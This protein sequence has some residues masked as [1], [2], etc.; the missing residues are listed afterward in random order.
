VSLEFLSPEPAGG[1]RFT[2][3]ARSPMERVA[4]EAGARFE[5]RDGWSVA[6]DYDVPGPNGSADSA[7]WADVS[8]LGKLELQAAPA[9]LA[10]LADVELRLGHAS[11]A[12]D[13]WWLPLHPERV[14]VVGEPAPVRALRGRLEERAT[15]LDVTTV[16]AAM[17]ILGP[18]ARDVI[19]RFCALDLRDRVT[20]VGGLRPGSIARTPGTIVREDADRFLMLFGAALGEHMWTVVADAA[21]HLGGRPVG[22]DGLP[23]L[24]GVLAGA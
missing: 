19:A 1:D 17:T 5:V 15:V 2:P 24:E 4:R 22:V 20:P 8:H 6:V 21:T 10:A 13:A 11:R 16:F 3:I 14:L 12:G 18:R 7:A 23:A 9:E